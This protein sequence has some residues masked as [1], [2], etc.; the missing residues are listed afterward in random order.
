MQLHTCVLEIGFGLG[1]S[2]G[3]QRYH[4]HNFAACVPQG[5]H[6]FQRAFARGNKIFHNHHFRSGAEVALDKVLKAVVLGSGAHVGIRKVEFVGN[7]RALGYGTGGN[8]GHTL[9]L[10]ELLENKTC[11]LNLYKCAHIGE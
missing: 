3:E 8:A 10:R 9:N 1:E 2:I 11:E 4:T 6:S 7:Q 5:F